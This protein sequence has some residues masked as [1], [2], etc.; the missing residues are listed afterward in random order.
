MLLPRLSTHQD[1]E[2]LRLGGEGDQLL[3]RRL[4]VLG[5]ALPEQPTRRRLTE[6]AEVVDDQRGA[7]AVVEECLRPQQRGGVCGAAAR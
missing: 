2:S 1:E 3:P 4:V 7:R 5:G 6:E